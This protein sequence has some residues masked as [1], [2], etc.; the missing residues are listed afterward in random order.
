MRLTPTRPATRGS[1]YYLAYWGA[2]AVYMPF[3]SL[4]F[5]GL[6]LSGSQ[7]GVIAALLPLMTLTVAPILSAIADRRGWRVRLLSLSLLGMSLAL[8]VVSFPRTFAPIVGAMALLAVARS[9]IGPIADSL[10]ARMAARHRLD[11]GGMRLWGSLSYALVALGC[12]ALWQRVGFA[13]MFVA[14]AALLIPVALLARLLEEG[15]QIER[16]ARRPLREVGRDRGLIA[17]LAATFAVGAALGMDSAFQSVYVGYLGGGGLLAGA[18]FGVSAFCEL[19]TMRFATA[20][21]RRIGAPAVLLLAYGLLASNYAGFALARAPLV[22][23]PL[24]V[25]KGFGF[26]LY[27]VSTV[28]LVDERTPPEWAATVQAIMNAGAG[29]L[30]PLA[31]SLLG[32]AIYDAL[33]PSSVFVACTAA[34]GLAAAILAGAAARGAFRGTPE[35]AKGDR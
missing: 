35:L 9:S 20:L 7:L 17:L 2:G 29:G 10:V 3:V 26:G 18:L 12:G 25:L 8:V 15:P 32:G 6:G 30:T 34:V 1:L 13:P 16:A 4:Y 11:Y 14:S 21:A 19:P 23:I 33:G 24:T 5:A 28:R 22:L 27:F 31:A